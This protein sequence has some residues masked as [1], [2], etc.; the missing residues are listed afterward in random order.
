M[1]HRGKRLRVLRD[2]FVVAAPAGARIR[3]RLQVTAA[4]AAVLRQVGE[5]L[6][7]LAGKDLAVRC[8]DGNS[9]AQVKAYSRR[10]RKQE[11]TAGSSSRW[12]GAITRTSEDSYQLRMRNLK[13][14]VQSLQTRV[15]VI[16]ERLARPAGGA[17]DQG[18]PGYADQAER[19]AKQQRLQVLSARLAACEA[20]LGSGRLSVCRGGWRLAHSRHHLDD[21]DLTAE[22]WQEQWRAQRLFLCADGEADKAWGNETIR[23]NP[24]TLSL[25]IKLPAPLA[26]LANSRFGRFTLAAP[27][28]FP[29]RRAEAA[30]QAAGGAV[31]YD[32]TYNPAKKRWYLDASW[33]TDPS[34]P[35]TLEQVQYGPVVAV[36]VNVGHLAVAALTSDGQPITAPFTIALELAGLP[37]TARDARIRRAISQILRVAA[38][39]RC[40]AVVIEDLNFE[41]SRIQGR[42]Q[43]D[44]RPRRGR[45]GRTFR[46]SIAGIPTGQFRDRLVQMATNAN[47]TV[48][49]VDPAYTSRWGAQHWLPTLKAQFHNQ[50]SGHHAAAVVIGRRGLDQRAKRKG[51]RVTDPHQRMK[52]ATPPHGVARVGELRNP[53]GGPSRTVAPGLIKATA[54]QGQR[55]RKDS[56]RPSRDGSKTEKPNRQTSTKATQDRSGP[57]TIADPLS[58]RV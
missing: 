41:E 49:A 15:K 29:Y 52:R 16:T 20:T 48:V 9:D 39:H 2:P 5:H 33:K 35:L 17:D 44:N 19:F 1:S 6:G 30:A 32:I 42:E 24:N 55:T 47:I 38:D 4:E 12:A 26:H 22:Q 13:A 28:D 3:T 51:E 27:V 36:D 7:G 50:L 40:G 11:L 45:K 10:F 58:R 56:R 18:R 14:E 34:A 8:A 21:A 37:A 54:V 23:W 25:E 46:R 57:P 31:R 43:Q 53:L